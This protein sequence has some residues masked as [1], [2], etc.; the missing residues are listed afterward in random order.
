[1][2]SKRGKNESIIQICN[3][4]DLYTSCIYLPDIPNAK[5]IDFDF[6]GHAYKLTVEISENKFQD[7]ILEPHKC[8]GT[9]C[10]KVKNYLRINN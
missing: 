8:L 6:L 9:L 1:M 7:F 5:L 3:D 4:L 10:E 2:K